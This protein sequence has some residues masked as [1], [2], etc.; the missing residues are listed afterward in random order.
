M[1]LLVELEVLLLWGRNMATLLLI[2]TLPAQVYWLMTDFQ[3]A[4]SVGLVN[5]IL[6]PLAIVL[7][8]LCRKIEDQKNTVRPNNVGDDEDKQQGE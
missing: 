7:H 3:T 2:L 8:I 4:L 5:I 6:F 1:R